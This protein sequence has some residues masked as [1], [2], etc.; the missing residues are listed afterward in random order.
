MLILI[1]LETE[2]F[3]FPTKRRSVENAGTALKPGMD[4]KNGGNMA[5]EVSF[6]K[7]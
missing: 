7:I 2:L 6:E 5:G 3:T 4:K 1:V